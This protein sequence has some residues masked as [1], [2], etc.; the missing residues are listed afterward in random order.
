MHGQKNIKSM[1]LAG[2]EPAISMRAA[3]DPHLRPRSTWNWPTV[4]QFVIK[5]T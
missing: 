3:A 2:F 5:C 1:F 4:T